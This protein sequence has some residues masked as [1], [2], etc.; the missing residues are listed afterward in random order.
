MNVTA[1]RK[2]GEALKVMVGDTPMGGVLKYRLR[3][4]RGQLQPVSTI[5]VYTPSV[6][7][8]DEYAKIL[9]TDD[10]GKLHGII[11]HVRIRTGEDVTEDETGGVQIDDIENGHIFV[12]NDVKGIE[13]NVKDP[14]PGSTITLH[15]FPDCYGEF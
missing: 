12:A 15:S 2:K 3:V 11:R 14:V 1:E 4:K 5:D 7:F 13:F 9:G 10:D 8:V 6:D